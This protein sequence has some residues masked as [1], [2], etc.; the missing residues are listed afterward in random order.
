MA[1]TK[2]KPAQV[3]QYVLIGLILA[4]AVVFGV[5]CLLFGHL[6]EGVIILVCSL[7]V[8]VV[9]SEAMRADRKFNRRK[10]THS[11]DKELGEP[12]V[13]AEGVS[14]KRE[15]EHGM[16]A[17]VAIYETMVV[18]HQTDVPEDKAIEYTMPWNYLSDVEHV[19]TT[20][21]ILHSGIGG[22]IKMT[23]ATPL[24]GKAIMMVIDQKFGL[25][26]GDADSTGEIDLG[27]GRKAGRVYID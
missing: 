2:L 11:T 5:L 8:I 4:I 23:F 20:T 21:V 7:V 12:L 24:K 6:I 16:M 27:N 15:G 1:K 19:S 14:V 25:A 26:F 13:R 22:D 18:V 10:V 3:A 9:A 17:A